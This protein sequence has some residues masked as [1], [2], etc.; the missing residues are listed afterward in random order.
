MVIPYFNQNIG[1][2][3]SE[4]IPNFRGHLHYA[5][6]ISRTQWGGYIDMHILP[7]LLELRIKIYSLRPDCFSFFEE[8]G[9]PNYD[10][11]V[12]VLYVKNVHYDYLYEAPE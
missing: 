7:L 2:I 8:I 1:T 4:N 12:S 3:L 10:K 11:K 9:S 6:N 5:Q